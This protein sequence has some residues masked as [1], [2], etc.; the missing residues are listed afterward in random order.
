MSARHRFFLALPF[1]ISGRATPIAENDYLLQWAKQLVRLVV[2]VMMKEGQFPPLAENLLGF[3]DTFSFGM[4]SPF[5][6]V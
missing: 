3:L 6:Q 2:V 1:L 5:I 4:S